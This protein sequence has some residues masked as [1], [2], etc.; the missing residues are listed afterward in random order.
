MRRLA[1][2]LALAFA[3][4]TLAAPVQPTTAGIGYYIGKY[5]SASASAATTIDLSDAQIRELRLPYLAAYAQSAY[6]GSV[7]EKQ[8]VCGSSCSSTGET[9]VL[10]TDGDNRAIP[11][12]MSTAPDEGVTIDA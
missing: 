12:G 7:N 3:T 10:W 6:C 2:L 8:W 4:P 11:Y 1:V 5:R 9:K